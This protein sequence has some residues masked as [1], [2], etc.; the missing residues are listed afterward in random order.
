MVES[1]PS[2]GARPLIWFAKA[3]RTCW[4]ASWQR[5]RTHGTIRFRM[6]SFSRSLENPIRSS[7]NVASHI[8]ATQT[9]NLSCSGSADFG[10]V[11]FKQLYVVADELLSNEFLAHR[12][13]KLLE[14]SYNRTYARRGHRPH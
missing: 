4:E 11:V 5:S 9:R 7:G 8:F 13:G 2:S 6:T 12:L 3:A 1:F 10:F 14:V